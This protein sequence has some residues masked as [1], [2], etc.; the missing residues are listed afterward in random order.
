MEAPTPPDPGRFDDGAVVDAYREVDGLTP[1]E[2]HLVEAHVPHGADVL[3][4]GVGTGRT[5]GELRARAGTYV[6]IDLA[7][8]MVE[9]ARRRHPE[10][11]LRVGDATELPDVADASVDA[12]LWSYNGLDYV[13]DAA[14]RRA[15][16]ECRRV[17]RPGGCVIASSHDPRA[18]LAAPPRGG[19]SPARWA[20]VTLLMTGRRLA[21]GLRHGVLWRGHGWV[22]DPAWGGL[23]THMATPAR[24][25]DEVRA[26]GLE[27]VEVRHGDEPRRAL[28]GR[29]PWWYYVARPAGTGTPRSR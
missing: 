4:L 29:T 9:V 16:A 3:D 27:V 11:D 19:S 26:A 2:R 14:R 15:W 13:A 10:A 8:R 7:P 24:V 17:L 18:V 22:V 12:V 5:V 28:V 1:C 20:A 25:R 6:G 23:P 21:R